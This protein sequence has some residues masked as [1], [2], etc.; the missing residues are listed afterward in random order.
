M[1]CTKV[2]HAIAPEICEFYAN[3][4][5]FFHFTSP[6]I[7]I[8]K[9]SLYRGNLSAG[10]NRSPMCNIVVRK[11]ILEYTHYLIG[12][13]WHLRV[14]ICGR[15]VDL[16]PTQ[17]RPRSSIPCRPGTV[18]SLPVA[19]LPWIWSTPTV[20]KLRAIRRVV[21]QTWRKSLTHLAETRS[22]CG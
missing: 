6:S 3:V 19:T 4:F 13:S 2:G 22:S 14:E 12:S 18:R 9:R 5:N 17:L 1:E 20:T 21:A 8:A 15:V 7:T 10:Q 11:T 16:S